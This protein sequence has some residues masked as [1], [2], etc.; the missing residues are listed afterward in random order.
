V[1]FISNDGVEYRAYRD[2][3]FDSYSGGVLKG[4]IEDTD[5]PTI[6]PEDTDK[7]PVKLTGAR[8][9]VTL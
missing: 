2:V 5:L 3:T 9:E 6:N 4:K 1:N 8:F 7:P